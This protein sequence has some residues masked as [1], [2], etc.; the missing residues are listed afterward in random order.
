MESVELWDTIDPASQPEKIAPV[1]IVFKN[2]YNYSVNLFSSNDRNYMKNPRKLYNYDQ[3]N[4]VDNIVYAGGRYL[5]IP[6][7]EYE[8]NDIVIKDYLGGI[9]L[10]TLSFG[11][12]NLSQ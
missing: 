5:V 8:V 10:L 3:Q 2:K 11:I 9:A 12:M 7:T 4:S 6:N 1:S